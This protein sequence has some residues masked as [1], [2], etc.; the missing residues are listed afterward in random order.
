M[1]I[2]TIEQDDEKDRAAIRRDAIVQALVTKRPAQV[3]AYIDAN[4]NSMADARNILKVL[5]RIIVAL[6]KDEMR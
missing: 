1:K 4:V 5:T 2:N 3:D 6:L